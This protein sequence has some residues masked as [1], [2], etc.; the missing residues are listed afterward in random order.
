MKRASLA[1]SF[2]RRGEQLLD[3]W[4]RG[5]TISREHM[6]S[7]NIATLL[8]LVAISEPTFEPSQVLELN[9]FPLF[10][11][12][13]ASGK[14]EVG[15]FTRCSIEQVVAQLNKYPQPAQSIQFRFE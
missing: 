1:T 10:L 15:V 4:T 13:V 7:R 6:L 2:C 5:D 9:P 11:S 12:F 14:R 8:Y 3:A